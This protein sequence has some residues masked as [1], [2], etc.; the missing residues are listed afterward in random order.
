MADANTTAD[1]IRCRGDELAAADGARFS[2]ERADHVC[3]FFE[4][5]LRL[6][7]GEY[8]GESFL[9]MAWQRELLSR[10]FGWEVWSADWGRWIRRFRKVCV[11]VPKKN[12]KSP[13][14]A[15]VGLYLLAA[16]GEPGQKVYSAARDGKQAGIVHRHAHE[17]VRRSPALSAAC[18]INKSTGRIV[19][20][21]TTSQYDLLSGDNISGQ[22]GLNGSVI[23]D[24]THVVDDRLARVL[25]HMGASRSEPMQ[26]EVSTAGNNPEGYGRRQWEY[27]RSVAAGDL[28]DDAFLSVNY[29][30]ESNASDEQCLDS[31]VWARA[32]P[33]WGRTIK[34]AEFAASAARAKQQSLG[35]WRAFKMYRLN[36]WQTGGATWLDQNKWNQCA[37]ELPA[38]ED[39]PCALGLDLSKTRDM[40][41]LAI[42][43]SVDDQKYL[44]VHHWVTESYAEANAHKVR[45]ADWSADG[46]DLTII[47]GD[48]I[49][50]GWIKTKVEQLFAN[51]IPDVFVYDKTYAQEFSE[52]L[53]E[54]S[55][56]QQ[57]EFGQGPATM[58]APID[59]FLAGVRDGHITHENAPCLNWQAGHAEVSTNAKGHRLLRKPRHGDVRKIDGLVAAVMASWGTAHI[60]QSIGPLF[61]I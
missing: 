36:Q 48:V 58:E 33:S 53:G 30:V 15:G 56:V 22:E 10:A 20:S 11:W 24:E 52:W 50:Q 2:A 21:E 25:E 29:G 8:A 42:C 43:W 32:N 3:D 5:E 59:D 6:Y 7:E 14:A 46:G 12:G 13:L 26:F 4:R 18:K 9:L 61:I 49:R 45:F 16:D 57:I 34:P 35:D 47:P 41:A 37:G 55:D 39:V 44:R 23:I 51:Q 17:M 28:R 38:L 31:A 27:G 1:W 60:R 19:F 54:V 40:S